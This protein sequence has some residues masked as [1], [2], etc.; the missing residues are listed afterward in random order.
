M[1]TVTSPETPVAAAAAG[2]G[3]PTQSMREEEALNRANH[4]D[5]DTLE[6]SCQNFAK[7]P[8]NDLLG[9]ILVFKLATKLLELRQT[10]SVA[11]YASEF[12]GYS[13][14]LS[15]GF[16]SDTVLK[17]SF[18]RGLKVYV[19]CLVFSEV[20]DPDCS[21]HQLITKSL[22]VD[23]AIFDD[24]SFDDNFCGMSSRTQWSSEPVAMEIDTISVGRLS[25]A[26]RDFLRNNNGCFR[27]TKLG[28]KR[29][30][31]PLENKHIG[32]SATHRRRANQKK[33]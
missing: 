8:K 15:D 7:Q 24:R 31:C 28:H 11:K 21:L 17:N 29:Y 27:C 5:S 9:P 4:L 13:S 22:L 3:F 6:G 26:E 32:G 30:D 14:Y 18:Y 19:R 10:S 2:G 16:F 33:N 12:T 25:K 23:Y 20:F 1:S